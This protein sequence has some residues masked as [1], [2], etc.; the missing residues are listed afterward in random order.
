MLLYQADDTGIVFHTG[1]FKDVY[2]QILDNPQ[3]E[4]CFVDSV[5][6]IQVRVRGTLEVVE[7]NILKEEI[8]NHPTRAFL[9]AWKESGTLEDFYHSF[10]VFR[11]KNGLANVWTFETNAAPK[12]DISL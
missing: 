6:N 2:K 4:L 12:N 1:A 10:I 5:K 7:D 8:S 3:V 9:K 11:M